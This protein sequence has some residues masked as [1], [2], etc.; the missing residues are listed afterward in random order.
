[1]R[2]RLSIA[3]AM[4]VVLYAGLGLAALR[5]PSGWWLSSLFSLDA[6]ALTVAALAAIYR[7]GGQRSFWLGVV[8]CGLTY[9]MLV[10]GRETHGL[11]VTTRLLNEAFEWLP[12]PWRQGHQ[13]LLWA[14]LERPSFPLSGHL[15]LVGPIALV[16][17]LVARYLHATRGDAS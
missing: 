17:G 16:G 6:G 2:G 10:F 15:L 4:G 11:L 12:T 8:A 14:G 9:L 13:V 1:M 3:A 5:S 7:R